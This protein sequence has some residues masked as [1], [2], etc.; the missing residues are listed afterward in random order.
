MALKRNVR[1]EERKYIFCGLRFGLFWWL[2]INVQPR[3][4]GIDY[5]PVMMALQRNVRVEERKYI[6]CGLRFGLF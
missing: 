1:V 2:F 6:F 5:V 4:V 3:D